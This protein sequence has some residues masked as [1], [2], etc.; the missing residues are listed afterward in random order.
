MADKTG[1]AWTDAT[2][3]PVTGCT[4]VSDGCTNC[5]AE[6]LALRLQ[7]MGSP[8]YADGFAVR[9]HERALAIPLRWREPRRVF[10]NS[11]SDLFHVDVPTEFIDRVFA[12]MALSPWHTYQVLTKRPQRA[13]NYLNNVPRVLT[14]IMAQ[15]QTLT[16]QTDAALTWP[17]PNVWIGTSVEDQRA[18]HRIDALLRCPAAVRFL[19]CEPL[20]GPLS[21]ERWLTP[22]F[23]PG[24]P[25]YEESGGRGVDWVIVGGE[26]GPGFRPLDLD[27]ARALRDEC[28][29][30]AVSFF[31][32]Q[33]G[34]ARPT[35]GGCLLD[36]VEHK[37]FPAMP[38]AGAR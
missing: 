30:G 23:P 8:K 34:G 2:W 37:A 38:V 32:K 9:T 35:S 16:G 4:K 19:S 3:N 29:A 26:S 14:A 36:G 18:A 6:T 12:V 28:A 25:R 24:D 33:V 15:M 11:M 5:Y 1:I 10:V 13:A 31:F 22:K 27:W 20:I 17:L 21:I 7:A